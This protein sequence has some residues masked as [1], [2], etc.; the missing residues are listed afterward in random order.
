MR[1]GVL[2]ELIQAD[3]HLSIHPSPDCLLSK[4]PT[5][6]RPK[7]TPLIFLRPV[8]VT[9]KRG[10]VD[11]GSC[12]FLCPMHRILSHALQRCSKRWTCFAKQQPGPARQNFS[13]PSEVLGVNSIDIKNLGPIFGPIFGPILP[14]SKSLPRPAN[15]PVFNL[16]SR[17]HFRAHFRAKI[18][19][20]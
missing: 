17:A 6:T 19:V 11:V 12:I 14:V 20:N 4:L 8:S 2:F 9:L 3:A 13:Q 5:S 1:V 7:A 10:E 18:Y 16:T 15:R